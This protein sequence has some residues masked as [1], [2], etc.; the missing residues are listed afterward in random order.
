MVHISLIHHTVQKA[1]AK[2]LLFSLNTGEANGIA[3]APDMMAEESAVWCVI[4]PN[5]ADLLW[6]LRKWVQVNL[7]IAAAGW[8]HLFQELECSEL[9]A[10]NIHNGAKRGQDFGLSP[11]TKW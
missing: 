10:D 7:S 3:Y 1:T 4:M 5:C 11:L 6:W 2:R 9:V 8:L